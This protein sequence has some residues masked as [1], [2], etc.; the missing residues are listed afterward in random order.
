MLKG[1]AAETVPDGQRRKEPVVVEV[2]PRSG[3]H[4]QE[5]STLNGAITFSAAWC[6]AICNLRSAVSEISVEPQT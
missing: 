6:S 3:P 1:T 4:K 2:R 5:G